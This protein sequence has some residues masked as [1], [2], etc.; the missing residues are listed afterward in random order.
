M[1]KKNEI[2]IVL[3][4][5]AIIVAFI[6][7]L[8]IIWGPKYG[9]YAEKLDEEPDSYVNI[10]EYQMQQ[11]P[12]LKEAILTNITIDIS[13]EELNKIRD[14]LDNNDTQCIKYQNDFYKIRFLYS[15]GV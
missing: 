14:F 10:T 13:Y 7:V 2:I 8:N 11:F 6:I 15:E 9:C 5:I 1:V 12:H 4:V 3:I